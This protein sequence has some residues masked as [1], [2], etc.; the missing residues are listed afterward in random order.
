MESCH[1]TQAETLLPS[2]KSDK[3][4]PGIQTGYASPSVC[5]AYFVTAHVKLQ[6][7]IVIVGDDNFHL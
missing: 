4:H 6:C 7:Y 5:I 3:Q 2:N 1:I